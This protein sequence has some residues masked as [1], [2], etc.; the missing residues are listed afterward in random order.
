MRHTFTS[1]K[2]LSG[3]QLYTPEPPEPLDWREKPPIWSRIRHATAVPIAAAAAVFA[4]IVLI[5]IA[6]VWFNSH[7]PSRA[8]SQEITETAATHEQDSH[9]AGVEANDAT[10][11]IFVHV[12]G[13]VHTPGV[14]ELAASARVADAIA[15]AGGASDAAVLSAINLA[16]PLKDGEQLM[17]PDAA[18]AAALAQ[19]AMTGMSTAGASALGDPQGMVSLNT[20]DLAALQTLPGV[21]PALA[22]RI[23]T[24]R[25]QHGGFVSI[26][27]LLNVSGIGEKTFEQ[28]R[29][30][31]TV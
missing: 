3:S 9:L 14:Y 31:V 30:L 18:A 12:V 8:F 23:I 17:V 10:A 25:E 27:Q 6:S 11:R 13:E 15:S 4:A 16:R 5:S 22:K 2:R 21:G 7:T 29:E 1:S 26:E 20:A 28:L 19:S 24:W